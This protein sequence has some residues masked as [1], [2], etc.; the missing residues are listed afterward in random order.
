MLPVNLDKTT[1]FTCYLYHKN[2]RQ[3]TISTILSA[4]SYRH[5]IAGI[6]G[7]TDD[8]VIQ[9]LLSGVKR[10]RPSIDGR[11]PITLDILAVLVRTAIELAPS[12]YWGYFY[13][14]VFT[15]AQRAFLRIGEILPSCAEDVKKVLQ[16]EDVHIEKTRVMISLIRFKNNAKQGTQSIHLT[17][18][19]TCCPVK[20]TKRYLKFRGKEPGPFFAYPNG[21]PYLRGN[22][23][24]ML[25][26]TVKAAGYNVSQIKGHSFRIGGATQ[27]AIE[28]KSDAWIRNMGR[29]TSDAYRKYIRT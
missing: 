27:A 6:K 23:D 15:L 4:I 10:L 29:W 20:L 17:A 13:S 18:Q 14:T 16:I 9:K 3:S 11:I 22:F 19:A 8:F 12:F 28:G 21:F 2:Y 5:K 26:K 24:K 7:Y 1:Q 25:E